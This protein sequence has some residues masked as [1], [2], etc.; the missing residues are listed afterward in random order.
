[1]VMEVSSKVALHPVP[2]NCPIKW[3]DVADKQGRKKMGSAGSRRGK[4]S[5]NKV[6]NMC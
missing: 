3:R 2:H 5:D 1:M 4:R 6:S